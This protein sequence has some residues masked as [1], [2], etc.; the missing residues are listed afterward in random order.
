MLACTNVAVVAEGK[1]SNVGLK[2]PC[3]AVIGKIIQKDIHDGNA[4]EGLACL[5][6]IRGI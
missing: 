2:I 5:T 6:P 1:A 3:T 4:A